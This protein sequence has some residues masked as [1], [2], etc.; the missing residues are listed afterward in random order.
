MLHWAL[1]PS[2]YLCT[3]SCRGTSLHYSTGRSRSRSTGQC[4]QDEETRPSFI[5]LRT[6][7]LVMFTSY[8]SLLEFTLNEDPRSNAYTGERSYSYLFK[9]IAAYRQAASESIHPWHSLG[10]TREHLSSLKAKGVKR[11]EGHYLHC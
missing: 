6:S 4:P 1:W 10:G 11:G 7:S 3:P 9:H 8:P 5:A 2:R